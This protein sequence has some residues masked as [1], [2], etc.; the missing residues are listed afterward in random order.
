MKTTSLLI[1]VTLFFLYSCNSGEKINAQKVDFGIYE[2]MK[3]K[4]IP[5][6]IFDSITIANMQPE[7][8]KQLPI[9]GYILKVDPLKFTNGNMKLVKTFYTID[10]EGKYC[11]VVAIKANST[12]NISDIQKTKVKNKNIEIYFNLA[13]SKKWAAMTKN[14]IGNA[15]AFIID[16]QIYTMPTVNAEIRSGTALIT[17]IENEPTAEKISASLNSSIP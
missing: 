16:N 14:N 1:A 13:G 11:A 12:M 4:D 2:T 10:K 5:A 9:I 7:K 6:S 15:V 8:D 17:G 3:A